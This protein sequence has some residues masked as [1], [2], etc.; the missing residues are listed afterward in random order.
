MVGRTISSLYQKNRSLL[1]Y[2]AIGCVSAGLDFVV[3]FFLV[4]FLH[5]HYLYANILSIIIGITTSFLL[6]R[7][8]NFKVLDK[9]KRRFVMFLF[10]GLSGLFLSSLILYVC[11]HQ[12]Q[13]DNL[14]SKL[15]S[16]ILVV[17]LQ[18]L[19]NK[20]VTFKN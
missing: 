1:L 5:V 14:L 17:F 11:V 10:V 7:R 16:I 3:Y 18:F 15:L 13:L 6:N 9:F 20:N 19:T 12:L 2:G 8:Y 4:N